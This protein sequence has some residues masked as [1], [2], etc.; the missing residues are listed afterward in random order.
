MEVDVKLALKTGRE[1]VGQAVLDDREMID[2][3]RDG[4]RHLLVRRH[5]L[6]VVELFLGEHRALVAENT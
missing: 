5:A 6:L 2:R 4:V 3:R 1:G